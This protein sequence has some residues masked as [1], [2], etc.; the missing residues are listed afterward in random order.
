ML[1]QKWPWTGPVSIQ[2]VHCNAGQFI[3]PSLPASCPGISNRPH[4]PASPN[5]RGMG[6]HSFGPGSLMPMLRMLPAQAHE[7][8]ARDLTSN[9]SNLSSYI[10]PTAL[11][12]GLCD[13]LHVEPDESC[14]RII[15]P[16]AIASSPGST[17]GCIQGSRPLT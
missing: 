12:P 9:D 14:G 2:P 13:S 3:I 1:N 6:F 15:P 11:Q 17:S 10:L 5:L 8:G 4:Q 16:G 7:T